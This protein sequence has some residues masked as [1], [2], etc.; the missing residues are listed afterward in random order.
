MTLLKKYYCGN[1]HQHAAMISF[2][3]YC[4]HTF[5][6]TDQ[7]MEESS[8]RTNGIHPPSL[9]LRAIGGTMQSGSVVYMSS[10]C[11]MGCLSIHWGGFP[12]R[13]R[14]AGCN[15]PNF[16]IIMILLPVGQW[17][18]NHGCAG[19]WRTPI[20]SQTYSSIGR[21]WLQG[22]CPPCLGKA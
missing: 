19:C 18:R 11:T 22:W 15:L 8:I 7:V 21:E 13:R 5:L 6:M 17:R 14:H 3:V 2:A 12:V 4:Y 16:H 10:S 1:F 9:V 20:D